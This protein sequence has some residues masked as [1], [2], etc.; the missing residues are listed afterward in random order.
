MAAILRVVTNLSF[1][2]QYMFKAEGMAIQQVFRLDSAVFLICYARYDAGSHYEPQAKQFSNLNVC[3]LIYNKASG[4]PRCARNDDP[5]ITLLK[6]FG[7][8]FRGSF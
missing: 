7:I 2:A 4:L 5:S 6:N 1:S 3:K 8:E